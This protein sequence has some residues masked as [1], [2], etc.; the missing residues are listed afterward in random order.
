MV[1]WNVGSLVHWQRTDKLA[2]YSLTVHYHQENLQRLD[3]L[4]PEYPLKRV[5]YV[6]K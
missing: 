4:E 1:K 3:R 2:R 6:H 5:G